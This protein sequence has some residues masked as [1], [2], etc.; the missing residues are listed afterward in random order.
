[1]PSSKTNCNIGCFQLTYNKNFK[2]SPIKEIKVSKYLFVHL[3]VT[4]SVYLCKLKVSRS[5][6]FETKYYMTGAKSCR[7]FDYDFY[8]LIND[9]ASETVT[10]E[11]VPVPAYLIIK[12][13]IAYR[14]L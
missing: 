10:P 5:N 2:N 3:S 14:T 9:V 13:P 4:H 1:M 8:K 7:L 6:T 12:S 11:P